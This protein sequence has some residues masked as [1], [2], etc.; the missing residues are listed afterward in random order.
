MKAAVVGDTLYCANDG[1]PFAQE[2][3]EAVTHAYLSDKR[4]DDIGRFGLGVKSIR[5]VPDAP[6]VLS[7]TVSF[8]FIDVISARFAE[9]AVSEV[10]EV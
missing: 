5:G 7:R 8:S 3:L 9:V 10:G 1:A 2:G 6:L 4:G